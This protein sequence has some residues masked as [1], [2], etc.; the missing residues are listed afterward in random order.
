MTSRRRTRAQQNAPHSSDSSEGDTSSDEDANV[1][2]P[3][4]PTTKARGKQK[5]VV[6]SSGVRIKK[7]GKLG[8]ISEMPL[9]V[10][11]EVDPSPPFH[12][13]RL[14]LCPLPADIFL[15]DSPRPRPDVMDE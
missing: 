15:P 12:N 7:R 13:E 5:A 6:K 1:Q 9:D 10:L 3:K 8:L 2:A 11:Y 4:A 14:S